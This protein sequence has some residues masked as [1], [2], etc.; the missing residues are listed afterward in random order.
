[1]KRRLQSIPKIPGAILICALS[2]YKH[3]FSP[4]FLPACRYVP[5][6]SEYARDAIAQH[7]AMRG[8]LMA[9]G[10]LLRCNPLAK[11][12]F[13]PVPI[14][15][16]QSLISGLEGPLSQTSASGTRRPEANQ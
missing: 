16:S 2:L 10:R 15:D 4:L 5:S 9:A 8:S 7:G 1:M 14:S 13:D 12:G 3:M 6:C 11:G